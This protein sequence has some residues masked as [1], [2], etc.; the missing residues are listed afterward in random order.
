MHSEDSPDKAVR[1]P[2]LLPGQDHVPGGFYPASWGFHCAAK[3]GNLWEGG[4][5]PACPAG[6]QA[7]ASCHG[8][9]APVLFA[10]SSSSRAQCMRESLDFRE[11]Y[12]LQVLRDISVPSLYLS[13]R[14]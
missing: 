6:T 8:H 2:R 12:S 13:P 11:L 3:P 14:F 7:L 1:R 5:A 4:W 10:G 9:I